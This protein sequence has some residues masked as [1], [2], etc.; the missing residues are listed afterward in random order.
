MALVLSYILKIGTRP[1]VAFMLV[2][3]AE[4]GLITDMRGLSWPLDIIGGFFVTSRLVLI[5]KHF[6]T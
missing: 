3:V 1:L 2:F 4:F 6:S 5:T